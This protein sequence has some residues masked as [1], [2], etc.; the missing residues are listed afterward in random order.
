MIQNCKRLAS[1]RGFAQVNWIEDTLD[2]FFF[3]PLTKNIQN[4]MP[5]AWVVKTGNI[6]NTHTFVRSLDGNISAVSEER[7][8]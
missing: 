3:V 7:V 1:A 8:R 5:I 4:F 2:M 6:R